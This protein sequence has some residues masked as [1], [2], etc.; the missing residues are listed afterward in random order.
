MLLLLYVLLNIYERMCK[1]IALLKA[2]IVS[3]YLS[4]FQQTFLNMH[5]SMLPQRLKVKEIQ[6]SETLNCK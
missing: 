3:N 4:C 6:Y 1:A 2:L 5:S